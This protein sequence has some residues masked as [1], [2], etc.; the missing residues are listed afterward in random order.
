MDNKVSS[1]ISFTTTS[2]SSSKNTEQYESFTILSLQ[3]LVQGNSTCEEKPIYDLKQSYALPFLSVFTK[4]PFKLQQRDVSL[5][6]SVY[7]STNIKYTV[8]HNAV[9]KKS[10]S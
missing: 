4:R 8:E 6:Y 2:L 7:L 9:L 3:L 1:F 10:T 5:R